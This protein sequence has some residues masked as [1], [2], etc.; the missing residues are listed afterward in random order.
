[1][2]RGILIDINAWTGKHSLIVADNSAQNKI[3]LHVC[4]THQGEYGRS[5]VIPLVGPCTPELRFALHR[6]PGS[7]YEAPSYVNNSDRSE[8]PT[9][10]SIKGYVPLSPARLGDH[11]KICRAT[12]E[13]K[14]H[15]FRLD[16]LLDMGWQLR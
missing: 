8:S 10:K 7:R 6:V 2:C 3:Q 14:H 15:S 9:G 11:H 4:R 1:M 12:G 5:S 16:A 13:L